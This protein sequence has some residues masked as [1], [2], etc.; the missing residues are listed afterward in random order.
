MLLVVIFLL[1]LYDISNISGNADWYMK[2]VKVFTN[3]PSK[4]SRIQPL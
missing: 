3:G 4:I 1:M 2:W